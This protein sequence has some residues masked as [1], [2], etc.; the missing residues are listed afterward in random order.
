MSS[1]PALTIR[2]ELE[3]RPSVIVLAASAEDEA[4]LRAWLELPKVRHRLLDLIAD[5]LDELR[6]AA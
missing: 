3:E 5:V 4:H 6:E 1:P 2:V